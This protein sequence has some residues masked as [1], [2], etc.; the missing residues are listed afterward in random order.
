MKICDGIV[1]IRRLE[2]GTFLLYLLPFSLL[3]PYDP[4]TAVTYPINVIV[5][6]SKEYYLSC[7]ILI[8]NDHF[9]C[10]KLCRQLV[11]S[12]VALDAAGALSRIAAVMRFA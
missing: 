9:L 2:L 11:N 10:R 5:L 8:D 1:R 3:F 6:F 7:N 4:D 12:N